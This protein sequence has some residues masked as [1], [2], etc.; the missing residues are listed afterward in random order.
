MIIR[1]LN[2]SDGNDERFLLDILTRTR[3][4]FTITDIHGESATGTVV[5]YRYWNRIAVI[6]LDDPNLQTVFNADEVAEVVYE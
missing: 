4:T 5:W 1:T 2:N 3:R 6:D